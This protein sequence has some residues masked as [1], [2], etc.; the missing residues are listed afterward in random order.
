MHIFI[1][2]R[3]GFRVTKGFK[4]SEF[5]LFRKNSSSYNQN[6]IELLES[7]QIDEAISNNYLA[8]T[9]SFLANSD[10]MGN[11]GLFSLY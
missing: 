1:N 11:A 10:P 8:D 9:L 2:C 5:Y 3:N 7:L 4:T 6:L